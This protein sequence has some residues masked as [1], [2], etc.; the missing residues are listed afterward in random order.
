M[1]AIVGGNIEIASGFLTVL[2][3]IIIII[4]KCRYPDISCVLS[5]LQ[6]LIERGQID[7]IDF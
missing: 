5:V 7:L 4:I 6:K 1:P 3:I 2:S